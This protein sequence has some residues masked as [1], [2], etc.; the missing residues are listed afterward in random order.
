[1]GGTPLHGFYPRLGIQ[2]RGPPETQKCDWSRKNKVIPKDTRNHRN[3][4]QMKSRQCNADAHLRFKKSRVAATMSDCAMPN[5]PTR[6][7]IAKVSPEGSQLWRVSN[8]LFE[9]IDCEGKPRGIAIGWRVEIIKYYNTVV[10]RNA[11][12]GMETK[13]R[14]KKRRQRES[15]PIPRGIVWDRPKIRKE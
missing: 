3:S 8:S 6:A 1:M 4:M 7:S 11:T 13:G 9:L 12:R 5:M 15:K 10:M 14:N 2:V